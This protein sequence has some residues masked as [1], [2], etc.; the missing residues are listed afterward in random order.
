MNTA[1]QRRD[2]ADTGS[3]I[4]S[5]EISCSRGAQGPVVLLI[6]GLAG[7]CGLW[8][9]VSRVLREHFR[10]VQY[11][12]RGHGESGSPEGSWSLEDFVADLLHVF[13]GH[14]LSRIH[15]A[16]FSLGGLIAQRFAIDHSDKVERLA[17]VSA[18][19]GR[20][21]EEK[22][23]VTRRLENLWAGDYDTNIEAALERWF[24]PGFRERHPD[25]VEERM[26]LMRK[27]GSQRGYIQAYKVFSTSDLADELQL[28][29]A[30][31]LIMTGEEDPGSNPRMAALMHSRISGSRMEILPGLRHSL[32]VEAPELV[33]EKL[34][35]FFLEESD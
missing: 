30:P 10:V 17:I 4:Y 3:V 34:N 9:P 2:T 24:S 12:L 20:T 19:A 35:G 11:D 29:S 5:E 22:E 6:H 13:R 21:G 31:T 28:I 23:K 27:V 7:T 14:E 15:L 8:N 1:A 33:A 25:L 26:A 16:G 18:V 32:L